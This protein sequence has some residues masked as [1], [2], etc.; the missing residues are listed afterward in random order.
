[1]ILDT[2]ISPRGTHYRPPILGNINGSASSFAHQLGFG[3]IVNDHKMLSS[4]ETF[5]FHCHRLPSLSSHGFVTIDSI[6]I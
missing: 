2:S 1:M 5:N 4:G 6:Y 3:C